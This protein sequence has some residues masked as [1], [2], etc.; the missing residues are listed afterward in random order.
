MTYREPKKYPSEEY[1]KNWER[2]FKKQEEPKQ[3]D[4]VQTPKTTED[5]N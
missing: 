3:N 4:R 2:I 1:N 5:R